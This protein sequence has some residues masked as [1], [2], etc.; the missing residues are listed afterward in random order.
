MSRLLA[1]WRG[2]PLQVLNGLLL[3]VWLVAATSWVLI[4]YRRFDSQASGRVEQQRRQALAVLERA[5][6]ELSAITQLLRG[7]RL[8][9]DGLLVADHN[10]LLDATTPLLQLPHVQWLTVYDASGRIAVQPHKAAVF[11]QTDTLAPWLQGTL[12]LQ[13]APAVTVARLDGRP[14][15]LHGARVDDLN[16]TIGHVAVGARLDERFVAKL[17]LAAGTPVALTL[18]DTPPPAGEAAERS[19]VA[20]PLPPDLAAGGLQVHLVNPL[21]EARAAWRRNL[22][23]GL[24]VFMAAGFFMLAVAAISSRALARSQRSLVESRDQADAARLAM[25]EALARQNELSALRSRFVAMTSHEFRTP[26][27]TI[28]SSAQLLKHYGERLAPDEK[29]EVLTSIEGG[30]ERMSRMLEKVLHISRAEARMLDFEPR[31][32]DLMALCRTVVQEVRRQWPET[33]CTV[34]TR[35][36]FGPEEGVFDEKL[37]RHVLENL[38]ANAIKYSPAG[39]M[40]RLEAGRE[41]G[42]PERPGAMVFSVSDQGIG[43]PPDELPHLFDPFHRASNVG[44]IPGTGLGLSIVKNSVERHGGSIAVESAPGQGT[45]FTVRL[46]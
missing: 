16:G 35:F 37:L 18:A 33:A 19:R 21:G 24:A 42:T 28:L 40:V 12:A 20:V 30:V 32:I 2:S 5:G 17:S 3:A 10:K 27:A 11:G 22:A 9:A 31:R 45:R 1:S 46:P 36:D 39:G 25:A 13:K 26:L 6:E 23:L 29:T 15:L 8:V 34:Q 4:E 43:I 41:P 38:L 14:Y 7:N 44:D